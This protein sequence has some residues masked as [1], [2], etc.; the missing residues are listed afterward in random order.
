[1]PFA[2]GA[3][4]IGGFIAGEWKGSDSP[5]GIIK[6]WISTVQS[7]SHHISPVSVDTLSPAPLLSGPL[8]AT[9]TTAAATF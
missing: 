4:W 9:A 1:M 3:R 2:K 8:S 6:K 7:S 5:R